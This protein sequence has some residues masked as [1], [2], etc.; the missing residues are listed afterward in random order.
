MPIGEA[1]IT[2]YFARVPRKKNRKG[3]PDPKPA[4]FKRRRVH[5]ID[6]EVEV[7]GEPVKKEPKR[8]GSLTFPKDSKKTSRALRHS[9]LVSTPAPHPHAARDAPTTEARVSSVDL[10]PVTLPQCS[11]SIHALRI[12][13]SPADYVKGNEV[14]GKFVALASLPSVYCSDATIDAPESHGATC[15]GEP[16]YQ[17]DMPS[18]SI[19]PSSQSQYISYSDAAASQ[20][21][22][23][24][25]SAPPPSQSDI[26]QDEFI[27]SSQSQYMSASQ[28]PRYR[29][30]MSSDA[31]VIPSSQSQYI[32]PFPAPVQRDDDGFVVP[33]LQS[34]WSFQFPSNGRQ[35]SDPGPLTVELAD[36]EI[37]PSS[38]SQFELELLPRTRGR[39]S[40]PPG[41]PVHPSSRLQPEPDIPAPQDIDVEDMFHH[42]SP[43]TADAFVDPP[44]DDSQ[45]ESD[46]DV[47][48]L[49]RPPALSRF[50]SPEHEDYDLSSGFTNDSVRDM[51]TDDLGSLGGSEPSSLGSESLPDAVKDFYSMFGNGEGSYP[52]DFPESLKWS[53]GDTQ[54]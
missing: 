13:P 26:S 2:S 5:D 39:S 33:S 7:I 20:P 9:S 22:R 44:A 46:D 24:N 28:I 15:H 11:P 40:S 3:L 29:G 32:T 1:P 51:P 45:T 30:N 8:Q 50:H 6:D 18:S 17:D 14:R 41:M 48:T 34:Q 37:V 16:P 19:V 10:A 12:T 25:L 21:D 42:S 47:P 31:A 43:R 23:F 27:P 53:A 38:Q 52:D 49:P 35:D 36:E 4:P 54:D